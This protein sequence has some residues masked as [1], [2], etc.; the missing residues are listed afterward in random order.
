M[1]TTRRKLLQRVAEKLRALGEEVGDEDFET[2]AG[3]VEELMLNGQDAVLSPVERLNYEDVL[4]WFNGVYGR[5]V[6]EQKS[7]V[8]VRMWKPDTWPDD[9]R[10]E[11][12]DVLQ[13]CWAANQFRPHSVA[14]YLGIDRGK[15]VAW[16]R[17]EEFAEW[18][19]HRGGRALKIAAVADLAIARTAEILSLKSDDPRIISTQTKLA[20]SIVG[21]RGM[22]EGQILPDK[23]D[24][25]IG[26]QVIGP[27][28]QASVPKLVRAIPV[29]AEKK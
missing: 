5:L 6:S 7:N 29:L 1:D 27:P 18:S 25:G 19:R 20:A 11:L 28:T 21:G 24:F 4:T 3:D 17:S 9:I 10:E 26:K 12:F 14:E 23:Q 13:I 22:P 8:G 15:C 16:L 2:L